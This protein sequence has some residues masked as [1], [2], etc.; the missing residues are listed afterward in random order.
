M[1]DKKSAQDRILHLREVINK[2]RY[3]YHV[4]DKASISE[5]ALDSLKKE[6]FDLEQEFPELVTPDSPTQRV[7]G[8]PLPEFKKVKHQTRMLSLN[9]AF[10]EVDMRDW[11]E[12]LGSYLQT[13]NYKLQTTP[14]FY[15][16][17]KMDGL[18]VELVYENGIFIE[19]STRG[20]GE[21]GEDITQNLKTIEAIPLRLSQP[22]VIASSPRA[23]GVA[24]TSRSNPGSGDK[25]MDRHGVPRDDKQKIPKK[26]VVR[27]ECFLTKKEFERINKEQ[28][29]KGEKLFANPRNVAAGSLRQLDSSI[30][31][32]RKLDFYGYFILN[33]EEDY[34]THAGRYAA[35]RNFGFKV[36]PEG[37]VAKSLEEVFAFQKE[38]LKK[39]D[40]LPFE[41]DGVV[42]TVNENKVVET[43]GI[44][45]KA[46]RGAIAYKFQAEE[47]TTIVE[48]IIVQVGR[49]G[50]LTPVAV[51][52]P[53]R[54]SGVTV[55]HSTLHNADEIARLGLKIGDTVIVSRAGDV[56]PK[57]I[58]VLPELRT[59]QE[60]AYH[61]PSKCPYDGSSV[62]I[63][64]VI[65]KCPNPQCGARHREQLYHFV[66]RGAFNIEGLGPKIIDRFLDEGLIDDAGDIF[67]LEANEIEVLERFGKKS[68]E[69]VVAEIAARKTITL[70][71]FIYSL[72]I[73]HVGEETALALAK[74]LITHNSQLTTPKELFAA[75]EKMSLDDLQGI[76]DI[77]PK[78]SESIYGWFQE[79]RN[80]ALLEELDAVGIRIEP[81]QQQATSYR[82]SGKSFVLTGTL[83]SMSRDDAKAK[84]RALG[85]D[86]SE[87]VSKKTSY[88]VAGTEPGSK[89]QKA[90]ELG[91]KVLN[92]DEFLK[93][94]S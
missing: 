1:I 15:C 4:L 93:L 46:P 54:V 81:Y 8:K 13:T 33:P 39:R 65:H 72:G 45:G 77:G 58:K 17:L 89:K 24:R 12:R 52:R 76:S 68:A 79:K 43:A 51:L 27:G 35:L 49:T 18:A 48:D 30:T 29:T 57:I 84:I 88:V 55:K 31:A 75:F 91:V 60:R 44:I 32:G 59:G 23:A 85:G 66:S 5:A 22:S 11:L 62:V 16:D 94:L 37:V 7:A 20:D 25:N 80:V 21:V 19:G 82:L 38:I 92:E 74:Q 56:I 47:G 40:K 90:D 50:A 86:I 3:E 63:D 34:K 6:L 10:S 69:N 28:A 83:A 78:V 26:L 61:M 73:L 2:Y 67:K 9:D 70:P 14:E 41:I 36:N 42:V 71:K 64:G 87:S 53:V